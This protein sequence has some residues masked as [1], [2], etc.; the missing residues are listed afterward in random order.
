VNDAEM[1]KPVVACFP[2][3]WKQIEEVKMDRLYSVLV[4]KETRRNIQGFHF[5]FGKIETLAWARILPHVLDTFEA[6]LN[7]YIAQ[8]SRRWLF[9]HAGVV[10]WKGRAIVVPGRSRSG[11]TILVGEFLHAG[12]EYYSDDLAA[13]D[14]RGWVHP[15]PQRLSFRLERVEGALLASCFQRRLGTRQGSIYAEG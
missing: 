14:A 2:R 5:L 9:V 13:F 12:A 3:G 6:D 10:A 1:L 4:A 15:F 7:A 8:A 11:K